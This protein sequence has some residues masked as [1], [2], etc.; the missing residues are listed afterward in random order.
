MRIKRAV[1]DGRG[2]GRVVIVVGRET[3]LGRKAVMWIAFWV[4]GSLKS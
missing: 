3:R 4:G 1:G 2:I